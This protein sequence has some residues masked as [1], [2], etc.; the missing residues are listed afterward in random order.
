MSTAE[1]K[2]QLQSYIDLV[3]DED[4]LLVLNEAAEACVVNKPDIIDLLSPA[5]L[6]V[7]DESIKQA[8]EGIFILHDEVLKK[9]A[10][11]QIPH[12]SQNIANLRSS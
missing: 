8:D 5:Q 1:I 9:S 7:L 10:V 2:K 11:W 12:L 6:L 4:E 3:D